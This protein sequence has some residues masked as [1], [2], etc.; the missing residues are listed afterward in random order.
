M[1]SN[2]NSI[3]AGAT[4]N[5]EMLKTGLTGLTALNDH[6]NPYLYSAVVTVASGGVVTDSNT[7]KFGFPTKNTVVVNE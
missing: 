4:M 3:G 1:S 7:E 5:L 6:Q 2:G